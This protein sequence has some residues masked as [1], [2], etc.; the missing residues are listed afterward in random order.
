MDGVEKG[1]RKSW[2]DDIVKKAGINLRIRL[3]LLEEAYTHYGVPI[4]KIIEP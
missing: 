3:N 1:T 4:N 2:K